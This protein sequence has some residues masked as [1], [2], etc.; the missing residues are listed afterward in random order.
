MLVT[1]LGPPGVGKRSLLAAM[2]AVYGGR[3]TV[4]ELGSA[5]ATPVDSSVATLVLRRWGDELT[6]RTQGDGHDDDA[7]WAPWV[8][9]SQGLLLVCDARPSALGANRR[10][11][12]LVRRELPVGCLGVFVLAHTEVPGLHAAL[13]LHAA[14]V[15]DTPCAAWPAFAHRDNTPDEMRARVLEAMPYVRPRAPLSSSAGP[16]R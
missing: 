11:V 5:I 1:L 13:R 15:R 10:F 3:L 9:G 4:P 6:I 8:R 7:S 12:D 16:Y 14:L 2:A